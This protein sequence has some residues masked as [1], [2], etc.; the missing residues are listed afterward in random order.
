MELANYLDSYCRN[1]PQ[2]ECY[3]AVDHH[4][5]QVFLSS[6]FIGH[7]RKSPLP[8]FLAKYF[9][10]SNDLLHLP[11]LK[12]FHYASTLSSMVLCYASASSSPSQIVS[13]SK[14]FSSYSFPSNFLSFHAGTVGVF[15]LLDLNLPLWACKFCFTKCLWS[16]PCSSMN[17]CIVHIM[18][19]PG[20]YWFSFTKHSYSF[21]VYFLPFWVP[22]RYLFPKDQYSS[23]FLIVFFKT[24]IFLI[25]A[26]DTVAT[27]NWS[28]QNVLASSHYSFADNRRCI[29]KFPWGTLQ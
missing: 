4:I 9:V 21:Y 10:L 11:A 19:S 8:W 15:K 23:T 29:L 6:F 20:F 28:G 3:L 5:P 2:E 25:E 13:F 27:L 26:A 22:R 16:L 24:L 14:P 18:V 17:F 1:C 7:N 12:V